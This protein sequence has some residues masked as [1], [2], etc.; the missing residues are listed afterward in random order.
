MSNFTKAEI[1][2]IAQHEHISNMAAVL[3]AEDLIHHNGGIFLIQRMIM[4]HIARAQEADDS[5]QAER[6]GRVL[7]HFVNTHVNGTNRIGE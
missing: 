2:G 7:Q 5:K 4:D 6:W 3:L 1:D